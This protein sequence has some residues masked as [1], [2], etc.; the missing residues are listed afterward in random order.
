MRTVLTNTFIAVL[1]FC[2]QQ[3]T[4][5]QQLYFPPLIGN[6]WDTVTPASLGWCTNYID[7]L[8]DYLQ[9]TNTKAFIILKDGKI[10][11]E[12]YFGTFTVDSLWYWA[13][14]GK[15]LTSVLIGIARQKGVL[16]LSDTVSTYLGKGW[17]SCT[18]AQED[19][20]TI[21][22]Q[23]T[24]TTGLDDGVPDKDCT[25]DTCLIYE[26]DAGTRWAYHNAPYTL[27]H[28]V[29]ENA[30]GVTTNNFTTNE[31]SLKTGISGLWFQSGY[32][33][34]F[35]SKAR[36]AARFGL[37]MLNKGVWK[38]DSI[39]TDTNYY[40]SMVNTSQ[41]INKSYGY[42]WW[43]NGKSSFMAPGFQ[44]QFPGP[45]V[46]AAP[47][48]MFCALGKN[49]QKIYV[50]P[51]QNLVV[52]RLG[53]ASGT[54]QLAI[55]GFDNVVW[56]KLN[57]LMCSSTSMA[58]TDKANLILTPNPVDDVLFLNGLNSE[59]TVT[60]YDNLLRKQLERNIIPGQS[61]DVSALPIGIYFIKIKTK[62]SV[63][64]HN[65]IVAR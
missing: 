54:P 5:A 63:T 52:I 36:S 18:Q 8:N 20:I 47:A 43:L 13:S 46:P 65:V 1:L 29:L 58:E 48:D 33:E 55:S 23:I 4:N 62:F 50:V 19:K 25:D 60:V 39:I 2:L 24:M 9:S 57:Q 22:N 27:T 35:A 37:L 61:I 45:L 56:L 30:T 12:K 17:T 34:V 14:A 31:L 64:S 42:L 44:A 59:A 41:N 10:A 28:A 32:N 16:S 7:T 3:N 11:H 21:W 15:S 40:N 53:D 6:T 38:N 26:A 51:S 49:D